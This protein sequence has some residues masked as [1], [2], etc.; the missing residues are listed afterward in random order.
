MA[1]PQLSPG[2][3][4]REVDLTVGR[5]DNV[6]NN[7][8]ALAGPFQLGPVNQAI[9]ITTEQ[10]L[11]NVFGKP[12]QLS[13][14]YEYWM[15]ASSYLSYGGVMKIVRTSGSNLVNANAARNA[16]G[17]SVVGQADL[18]IQN[19]DDYLINHSDDT[20]NYVFAAKN[21]GAWATD[22]KVCVIDNRADQILTVNSTNSLTVGLA[23]TQ[24]VPAG[25]VIVGNGTTSSLSGYFKGIVTGINTTSSQVYTKILTHVST[26]GT[27]TNIEYQ[28]NGVNRFS[29]TAIGIGTTTLTV[30]ARTD[31]YSEQTLNLENNTI[32]WKNIAPRPTETQYARDRGAKNDAIHVVVVDDRGKITGVQG[33]ILE[34]HIELSKANDTVSAVNSPQRIWWKEY[35][36]Q[37]SN[38]VYVGDNP[39]E[40]NNNEVVY[41]TRVGLTT[42]DGLWNVQAQ[43]AQFSVLGNVTY[44]LKGGADY[45]TT[46]STRFKTTLGD[47]NV[48]HDLFSNKSEIQVDYL[49]MGPGLDSVDESKAKA[50]YIMSIADLRKDC[51][52]VVSPHRQSV[53]NVS[54]TNTQTNNIISFFSSLSSTSYAVFDSGYK[55]TYDRFNNK[56]VYL[57]CNAD[58]AGLMVRTAI[59]TYPWFSP[60][61][62]ER[63]VLNNA[64]KLA[65][66]PNKSQQDQL[67]SQRINAILSI[68]GSGIL[69]HGDKTALSY[70][71]AFDR[72]NVRNLFLTIEQSLQRTAQ[73]VMF[74]INDDI[75]RANFVNTVT[76]YLKDIQAKRGLYDF[77]VVCDDSNNTPDVID[78]NEFRAD[79]YLKPTKAI[80]YVTL[81]FV[82]TRTGVSFEE[83]I[84]RV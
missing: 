65:Y 16:N 30:S 72:I 31:W 32:Y 49:L 56:F 61:G 26:A 84:G 42:A 4:V 69:L 74:N 3:I 64:I 62:Q 24:T 78:N 12:S 40:E 59:N 17:E 41:Q 38:Y 36:A 1:T 11:L 10:E 83:V 68:P 14:Q 46:D 50:Q 5:A 81:T 58:V 25:T 23:V 79:I 52:A 43:S 73:S 48:A 70:A 39:S 35:L 20:A 13:G 18:L 33:N 8:G 77:R 7:V 2:V 76:P 71:S 44:T 55:Y 60:A 34:K 75:T 80:D 67:Y 54:N 57:P 51:L 45:G 63:G 22:L 9:D 29:N 28:Q 15:S 82:A 37:N 21:P 6:L 53:V 27:E 19:F 66:N 47:L